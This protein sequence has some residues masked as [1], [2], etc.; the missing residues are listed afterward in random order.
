MKVEDFEKI[1]IKSRGVYRLVPDR[2]LNHDLES[3]LWGDV[4]RSQANSIK[5]GTLVNIFRVLHGLTQGELAKKAF[6]KDDHKHVSKIE[7]H[8]VKK[9]NEQTISDLS[10]VFGEG[11]KKASEFIY[12]R[13][14]SDQPDLG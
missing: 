6:N 9:P 13:M 10:T 2:D 4:F 1:E 14:E 7:N 3:H 11:F 8:E 5:I 12:A